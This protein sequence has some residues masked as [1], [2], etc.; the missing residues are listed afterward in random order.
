M[1]GNLFVRE[2]PF[3]PTLG[4]QITLVFTAKIVVKRAA[5]ALG[6]NGEDTGRR[7]G[8]EAKVESLE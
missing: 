3:P 8:R 4:M 5:A 7:W 6:V 2:T 1:S